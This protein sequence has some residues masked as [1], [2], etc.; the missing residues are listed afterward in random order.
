MLRQHAL[1]SSHQAGI[2]LLRAHGLH[3]TAVDGLCMS[4]ETQTNPSIGSV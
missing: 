3:G 1:K 4:E 2:S